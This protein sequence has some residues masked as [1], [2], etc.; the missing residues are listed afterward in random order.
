MKRDFNKYERAKIQVL[1]ERYKFLRDSPKK[2][3]WR[4]K[5]MAALD[6]A[7]DELGFIREERV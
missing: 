7:L 2:S 3:S 6:W 4:T 5:E 1:V